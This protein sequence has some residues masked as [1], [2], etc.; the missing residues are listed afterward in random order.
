MQL[1]LKFRRGRQASVAKCQ[2]L[3]KFSPST[4]FKENF[5]KTTDAQVYGIGQSSLLYLWSIAG[6][7]EH[8]EKAE[9]PEKI[10]MTPSVSDYM[11][12]QS[13]DLDTA[14]TLR[15]LLDNFEHWFAKKQMPMTLRIAVLKSLL[16][17]TDLFDDVKN[18]QKIYFEMHEHLNTITT[19]DT[20]FDGLTIFL[21]L[22]CAAVLGTDSIGNDDVSNIN[23]FID[24]VVVRGVQSN[25]VV[26][27]QYTLQGM[28]YLLQSYL[29]DDLPTSL[30]VVKELV[31]EEL[32]KLSLTSDVV[33]TGDFIPL[34]YEQV[35]WSSAFRLLEEAVSLDDNNKT[36]F[37]TVTLY[38]SRR[39]FFT[40][41][42]ACM[43]TLFRSSFIFFPKT[44]FNIR[45]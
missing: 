9:A 33:T 34:H 12:K 21:L 28:L 19:A 44:S 11:L 20:V 24:S 4:A 13:T 27:R 5:E 17:L 15:A 6:V 32:L 41:F 37:L 18:Y 22:K 38:I 43:Q 31:L 26:V 35:L 40:H 2:L 10:A 45:N 42:L 29:L 16:I 3:Q 30:A 1:K 25:N 8:G 14:S 39:H 36:N 7:L 23:K